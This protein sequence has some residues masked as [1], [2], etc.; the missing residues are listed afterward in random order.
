[1][2]V[3]DTNMILRFILTDNVEMAVK[4]AEYIKSDKII[5]YNEVLAEVIY[6]LT[7]TYSGQ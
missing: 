4:A 3:F 1:M 6:V 2:K 5:V 7:K